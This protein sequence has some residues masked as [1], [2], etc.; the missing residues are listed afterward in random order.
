MRSLGFLW[1]SMIQK[2]N[3]FDSSFNN[4]SRHCFGFS[5][6]IRSYSSG[7]DVQLT[8]DM[9]RIMEQRL[10]AIAYKSKYL[11]NILYQLARSLASRLLTS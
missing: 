9:I 8:S 4:S 11:E 1:R 7:S 6:L 10:T 2:S 3:N 5:S